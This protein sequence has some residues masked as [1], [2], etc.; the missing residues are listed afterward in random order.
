MKFRKVGVLGS[1]DVGRTLASGFLASGCEV[2]LGSRSRTKD[3]IVAWQKEAGDRAR[4]GD[5]SE[6]A[7]FGEVVV[8]ATLGVAAVEALQMAGIGNLAGKV[9]IDTTNPLDFSSGVPPK[10]SVGHTD[11]LGEQIQRA[12]PEAKVVKCFNTVGHTLMVKPQLAGG[13]PTMFICGND[14]AAK[15]TVTD[16]L[17]E[18]QWETSDLGGIESSRHIEPLCIVWVIDALRRGTWTQAFKILKA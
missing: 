2:M 16:L 18:W 1:G 5:F 8:L 14:K 17:T 7:A 12:A 10:L 13:P 11:S 6:A 15:E 9:V 4:I 3:K